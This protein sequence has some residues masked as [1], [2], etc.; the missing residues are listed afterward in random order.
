MQFLERLDECF[1]DTSIIGYKTCWN[2]IVHNLDCNVRLNQNYTHQKQRLNRCIVELS[3]HGFNREYWKKSN[4][5]R[6]FTGKSNRNLKA[7]I[8]TSL[9]KS[10]ILSQLRIRIVETNKFGLYFFASDSLSLF[11]VTFF[12]FKVCP[13][14]VWF[15]AINTLAWVVLTRGQCISS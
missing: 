14:C 3:L 10:S 1:I 7:R 2:F 8:V 9:V 13:N 4:Q 15:V 12:L 6:D 11:A 5:N